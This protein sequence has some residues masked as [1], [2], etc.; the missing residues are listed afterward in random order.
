MQGKGGFTTSGNIETIENA[1]VPIFFFL[2]TEVLKNN[3]MCV[4]VHVPVEAK[5]GT[6]SI[7][8]GVV[9]TLSCYVCAGTNSGPL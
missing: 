8:A 5:K 6:R 4:R 2:Y 7:G 1:S 3:Y 9:V